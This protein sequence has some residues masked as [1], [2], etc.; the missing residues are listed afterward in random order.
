VIAR[1]LKGNEV[2]ALQRPP[3]EL[4]ET[5]TRKPARQ[6]DGLPPAE[7]KGGPRGARTHLQQL[8]DLFGAS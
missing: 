6:A 5:G 2:I 7:R 8:L 3:L 4:V 1:G